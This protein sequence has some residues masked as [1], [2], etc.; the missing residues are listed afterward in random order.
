MQELSPVLSLDPFPWYAQVR[1]TSPV[2]QDKQ[3]GS[4][5]VFRY[6][7]VVPRALGL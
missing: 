7:T 6:D 1:A 4:W 2:F 5:N 3:H